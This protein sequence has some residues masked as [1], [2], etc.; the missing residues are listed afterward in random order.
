MTI[1]N[2]YNLKS[3]EKAIKI[4]STLDKLT[5]FENTQKKLKKSILP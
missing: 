4:Y 5:I 1:R 3:T 2:D